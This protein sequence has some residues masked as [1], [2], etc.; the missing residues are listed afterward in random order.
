MDNESVT[1]RKDGKDG[2]GGASGISKRNAANGK[3]NE[4]LN[5]H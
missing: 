4:I 1:V 5:G 3:A 2:N